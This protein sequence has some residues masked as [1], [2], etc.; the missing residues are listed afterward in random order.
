MSDNRA[1]LTEEAMSE[2]AKLFEDCLSDLCMTTG[3]NFTRPIRAIGERTRYK[4]VLLFGKE[5][6]DYLMGDF[7]KLLEDRFDEY[8]SSSGSLES[9]AKDYRCG[10][11][12]EDAARSYQKKMRDSIETTFTAFAHHINWVKGQGIEWRTDNPDI[13]DEDYRELGEIISS[14]N[15]I[16]PELKRKW[17]NKVED[18][19]QYNELFESLIP[20]VE[21]I[22][23]EYQSGVVA[24]YD[25]HKK[26]LTKFDESRSS[27][28]RG[29]SNAR[30][31]MGATKKA[32]NLFKGLNLKVR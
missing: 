24:I 29:V 7:L 27:S 12:A 8:E 5:I 19:A 25:V 32:G 2:Y 9:L 3:R 16:L 11:D 10:E 14:F 13:K 22:F 6:L 15:N 1:N 21:Y 30:V 28:N 18:F 17:I 23:T 20:V 31:E 26:E 4:P